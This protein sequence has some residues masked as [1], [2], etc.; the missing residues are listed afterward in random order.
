MPIP[1]HELLLHPILTL[2][3]QGPIRR[4]DIARLMPGHFKLT[5]AEASEPIRGGSTTKVRHR[6]GW[7]FTFLTKAKLIAKD[8]ALKFTY[9]A[10]DF[11]RK[12]LAD[13]PRGILVKDLEA[14][15][16]WKEAWQTDKGQKPNETEETDAL[17][18]KIRS[19]PEEAIEE[20]IAT[21]NSALA[22]SILEQ[23]ADTDPFHFEQIVLDLLRA[24]GYGGDYRDGAKVTQ[25][26]N[27][28]GIDGV[29]NEDRL[30]LDVIYVQAKRW[31]NAVGRPEIQ[32]FVGALA[33]RQAHKGV[34]ITTGDFH[35]NAR[36]YACGLSQK[37]IL[38]D[39]Q[40]L[41]E[42]MIEHNIGVSSV[43]TLHIKRLDSDYFEAD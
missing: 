1:T 20:A 31:K 19:T 2:A 17:D 16:G 15:P 24:M 32:N 6:T 4:R 26:S 38:I 7:A 3:C 8:P 33:G 28:G 21:L 27:D 11:G 35:K 13:H 29:I 14:L 37:V 42:L 12:F 41:A 30:G 5:E 18:W 34:F 39:G 9:K 10:T 23:L 25:K 36:D 43:K 40:K 22:A